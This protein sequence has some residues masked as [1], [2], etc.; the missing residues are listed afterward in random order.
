M[1]SLLPERPVRSLLF[2][3]GN[4]PGWLIKAVDSGADGLIIDLQDAVPS[5]ERENA[6]TAVAE[7][8]RSRASLAGPVLL[9]RVNPT[10]SAEQERDLRSIVGPGLDGI[11]LPMV[12]G[13]DDV[14]AAEKLLNEAEEAMALP[15]RLRM[16]PLLET[17]SAV[18]RCFD[19]ASA[20]DRTAYLGGATA[21][22]GD[23]ARSLGFEWTPE[24]LETLYLRSQ[25]LLHARAA[26]VHNPISGMWGNVRD[27]A[28]LREFA[29]ATRQLGYRGMMVIH[30]SHVP[31]VHEVFSPTPQQIAQWQA[32]IEQVEERSRAGIGTSTHNGQLL[33]KAHALT[34]RQELDR[35]RLL[36]L[37]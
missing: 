7:F 3:P 30:P 11:V 35:A 19:V 31:V 10:G 37:L 1:R 8:L 6:R 21:A 24:G 23:L 26:G 20:T 2:V 36:G 32:I 34:A 9:V 4:R 25:A 22:G 14:L 17:A 5:A 18:M 12:S 33:D 15:L 16:M 28:G 27:L 29:I 13:P